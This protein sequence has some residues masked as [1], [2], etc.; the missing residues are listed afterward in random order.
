MSSDLLE[1][2]ICPIGEACEHEIFL[3]ETGETLGIECIF[4]MLQGQREIQD[5]DVYGKLMVKGLGRIC[6]GVH[7]PLSVGSRGRGWAKA[8]AAMTVREKMRALSC[9]VGE[10]EGTKGM[11]RFEGQE[12]PRMNV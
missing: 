1:P 2:T 8:K 7:A 9:I 4:D 6:C 3:L 5:I 12:T 11:E 10:K